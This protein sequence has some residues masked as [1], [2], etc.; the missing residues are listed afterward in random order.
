MLNRFLQAKQGDAL[1]QMIAAHA[2]SAPYVDKRTGRMVAA[3]PHAPHS[4]CPTARCAAHC[5]HSL[6][7]I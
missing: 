2:Q 5:Q 6:A 4:Q 1:F 3:S 7:C